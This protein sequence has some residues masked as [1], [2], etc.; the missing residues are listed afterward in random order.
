M[1]WD[2]LSPEEKLFVTDGARSYFY[3][4]EDKQVIVSHTPSGALGAGPESPISVLAGRGRLVDAFEARPT[5]AEPEVGGVTLALLPRTPQEEFDYVVLEV[6]PQDCEIR[7]VILV[8]SQGNHTEFVFEEI[9]ENRDL[10]D[11]LFRF[12][13]PP[14]VEILLASESTDTAPGRKKP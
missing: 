8:D 7:R 14:G 5:D 9:R 10:P 3:V 13:V 6:G 2:Y 11:S 4:P 12:T 1:R